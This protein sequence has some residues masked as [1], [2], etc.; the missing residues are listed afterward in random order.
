V[1]GY[2]RALVIQLLQAVP[3][4]RLHTVAQR[5]ARWLLMCADRTESDRL[6][7]GQKYLA[8]MVGVPQSTLAA[9][10]GKL[11]NDG[12]ICCS[13]SA[14]TLVDRQGLE[15]AACACDRIVRD[16]YERLQARAFELQPH[17]MGDEAGEPDAAR[18]LG[19]GPRRPDPQD[20]Q[21]AGRLR[22]G[23]PLSSR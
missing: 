9:V 13:P 17:M 11:E 7:L 20:D 16:H 21:P 14:I 1:R 2:T 23:V 12:V 10:V 8:E 4:N 19:R 5:C 22:Q 15:T 18:H 3:C 6:E